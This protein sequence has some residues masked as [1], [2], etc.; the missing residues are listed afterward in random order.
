MGGVRG[1]MVMVEVKVYPLTRIG[2]GQ[3][4]RRQGDFTLG[5]KKSQ[6]GSMDADVHFTGLYP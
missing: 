2:T 3:V 5:Y 4:R 6:H 1:L